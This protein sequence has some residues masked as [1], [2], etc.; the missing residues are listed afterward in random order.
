MSRLVTTLCHVTVLCRD[1]KYLEFRFCELRPSCTNRALIPSGLICFHGRFFLQQHRKKHPS[2]LLVTT[3]GYHFFVL[4]FELPHSFT[5]YTHQKCEKSRDKRGKVYRGKQN[6][7]TSV[8]LYIGYTLYIIYIYIIYYIYMY[9][10]LN[11][12][13]A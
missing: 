13:A 11:L 8:H 4:V 5:Q 12:T 7:S 10:R 1:V 3:I 6:H 9:M 2:I